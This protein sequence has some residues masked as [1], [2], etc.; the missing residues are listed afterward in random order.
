MND[1]IDVTPKELLD[2]STEQFLA[3]K[4]EEFFGFAKK[5][6]EAYLETGRILT[7]VNEKLATR[8]GVNSRW[9]T[10]L[11]EISVPSRTAREII[12]V[13]R[14]YG[15]GTAV[16]A[17]QSPTILVALSS[18]SA[19]PEKV[20][21]VESRIQS[22]EKLTV[23][24]VKDILKAIPEKIR[25]EAESQIHMET[26]PQLSDE[27]FDEAVEQFEK[28]K[29]ENAIT[30]AEAK[31]TAKARSE[32]TDVQLLRESNR[33]SKFAAQSTEELIASLD[34]AVKV[35]KSNPES[36]VEL[37]NASF[38]G[39]D[40][41]GQAVVKM[42]TQHNISDKANLEILISLKKQIEI[43][44]ANA[45]PET[46]ELVVKESEIGELKSEIAKLK[47]EIVRLQEENE[48]F[49]NINNAV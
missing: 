41:F 16:T 25:E 37:A 13:Y 39:S 28:V 1:V 30:K 43:L 31:V 32:T 15:S 6:V 29:S 23:A 14:K 34:D 47:Q 24:E 40:S 38:T 2:N 44:K 9:G 20:S 27:D 19:D 12:Q 46:T 21:E 3:T 7:E 8:N 48:M 45:I 42:I 18:P 10:W 17:D 5:T 33:N 22:G 35:L 11:S 4:K 49:S 36:L 26:V